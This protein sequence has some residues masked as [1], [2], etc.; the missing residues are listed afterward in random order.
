MYVW[1]HVNRIQIEGVMNTKGYFRGCNEN[2]RVGD[3][4]MKI[5]KHCVMLIGG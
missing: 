2:K 1:P 5:P 3:F 4:Y